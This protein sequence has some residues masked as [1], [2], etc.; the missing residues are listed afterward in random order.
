MTAPISAKALDR[1]P[2]GD[3]VYLIE[4]PTWITKARYRRAM[5]EAGTRIW[6]KDAMI[7]SAR[8]EIL[9]SAPSNMKGLLEVCDL[10]ESMTAET[11][12]TLVVSAL[13]AWEQLARALQRAGGDFASRVAD[14]EFWSQMAPMVAAR[15]FLVGTDSLRFKRGPDGLIPEAT[16]SGTV[17]DDDLA[18]IGWRAMALFQP[19][20]TETKNSAS[21][22]PS[23]SGPATSIAA[24]R[25]PTDQPGSSSEK[26]TE[27]TP[28]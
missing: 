5:T 4:I 23:P 21:P 16:L 12:T 3:T 7:A 20:E 2:V 19:S 26:P 11:D 9:D 10:Y 22:R 1:F 15:C 8:Q 24:P 17:P 18:M 14:N 27:E 13:E 6:S 28:S 25:L